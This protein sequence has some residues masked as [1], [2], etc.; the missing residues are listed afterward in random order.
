MRGVVFGFLSSAGILWWISNMLVEDV[1]RILIVSAVILLVFY[2]S[3]FWGF[4][5]FLI[6]RMKRISYSLA[7]FSFPFFWTSFEF[8]RSLTSQLGFPWGS[9]GYS[10]SNL[11]SMIQIVSVTGLPGLTF[12]II[13]FNSLIYWSVIQKSKGRRIRGLSIVILLFIFQVVIGHLILR[14]GENGANVRVSLIQA[15]VLPEIKRRNEVDYRIELL[16][17]MTLEAR[18][19]GSDLI[20]WSETSIP[21]FYR[22]GSNCIR[23]IQNIAKEAGIPIIAG[24]PECFLNPK[25]KKREYYNSAFLISARGKTAGKY[26]K[27]YLVQFGEHLPFDNTFPVLRKI[28]LGQGDYS[29]GNKFTVLSQGEFQFATLICFESIFPRLVR[30]FV[31]NGAELLVN[32]TEDTWYGRTA[33]P[34][35]HAEMSIIRAVENRISVARCGNSGISMLVDPYGRVLKKSAILERTIINGEIPLRK[36]IS[37]YTKYGDLFAWFIVA[38]SIILFILPFFSYGMKRKINKL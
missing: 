34:Y 9:A 31:R 32:I 26:R 29:Q 35:Q 37:F 22:E 3:M 15:N 30:K 28:H 23:R 33:G 13:L 19:S 7:I 17:K 10:L 36:G 2:L 18:K 38:V 24:A 21:C 27:I 11:P 25:T 20:V 1:S 6:S 12:S 4:V 8:L 14:K 5:A 16:K